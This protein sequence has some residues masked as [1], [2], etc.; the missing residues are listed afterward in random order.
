MFAGN[1]ATLIGGAI[2]NALGGVPMQN[3]Q[4]S[5][6]TLVN[7]VLSG[8][9]ASVKSAGGALYNAG[10]AY[11]RVINCSFSNNTADRGAGVFVEANSA[12]ILANSIL[13][14]NIGQTNNFQ[15]DQIFVNNL[16]SPDRAGSALVNY[17]DI[18]GLNPNVNAVNYL[19][20]SGNINA[21]PQ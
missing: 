3:N 18:Q 14:G 8:N 11:A 20:G 7:C 4:V 19:G 9:S 12:V 15:D 5:Q 13:W 2:Y 10:N 17:C 21:D 6:L 1:T 16:S